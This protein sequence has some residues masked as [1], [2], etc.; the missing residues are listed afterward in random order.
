MKDYC[1]DL[2]KIE[3][4]QELLQDDSWNFSLK[5][6][7]LE[8]EIKRI[9]NKAQQIGLTYSLILLDR[10]NQTKQYANNRE[11]IQLYELLFRHLELEEINRLFRT[12]SFNMAK[13]QNL[14]NQFEEQFKRF[15]SVINKKQRV[16]NFT[17][18]NNTDQDSEQVNQILN[19]IQQGN[20]KTQ[21]NS[22]QTQRKLNKYMNN[23]GLEQMPFFDVRK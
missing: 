6:Q 3:T 22:D 4:K 9:E 17:S 20:K 16:N 10:R 1:Q 18:L 7:L 19:Q 5:P 21:N 23:Q 12:N 11:D 8:S 15:K 13:R 14:N 2:N